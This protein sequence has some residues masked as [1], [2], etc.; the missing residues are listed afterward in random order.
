VVK[1]IARFGGS[2]D[3]LVPPHIALDIYQCYN[4][5]SLI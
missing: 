3:H 1:E 4:L 2:V 5:K